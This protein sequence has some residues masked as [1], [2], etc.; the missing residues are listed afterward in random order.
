M[1]YLVSFVLTVEPYN[2][3]LNIVKGDRT[4][5]VTPDEEG[6]VCKIEREGLGYA[7]TNLDKV[8]IPEVMFIK[9]NNTE[10]LYYINGSEE[11]IIEPLNSVICSVYYKDNKFYTY[12]GKEEKE[13]EDTLNFTVNE[14]GTVEIKPMYYAPKEESNNIYFVNCLEDDNLHY[15]GIESIYVRNV[16]RDFLKNFLIG[17]H[18]LI[19]MLI[20][21]LY[22]CALIYAN[23]QYHIEYFTSKPVIF[24]NIVG[25]TAL[26]LGIIVAI[27]LL[28]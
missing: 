5:T 28:I 15:D 8:Y 6:F 14:D 21:I 25:I 1:Y 18:V 24:T 23:K 13:I 11:G 22:I 3:I 17:T 10:D 20:V 26:V 9:Y 16:T 12:D 7:F 4:F 27:I 19:F 2:S